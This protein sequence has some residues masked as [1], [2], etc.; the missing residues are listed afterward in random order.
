M[1]SNSVPDH[2]EKWTVVGHKKRGGTQGNKGAKNHKSYIQSVKDIDPKELTPE[3]IYYSSIRSSKEE[4]EDKVNVAEYLR[5]IIIDRTNILDKKDSLETLGLLTSFMIET[6]SSIIKNTTP[7]ILEIKDD[8]KIVITLNRYLESTTEINTGIEKSMDCYKKSIEG[9][10]SLK[11][12]S[13]ENIQKFL[14]T[15]GI[16]E[17]P[18]YQSNKKKDSEEFNVNIDNIPVANIQTSY[19]SAIG[20]SLSDIIIEKQPVKIVNKFSQPK[21]LMVDTGVVD[22]KIPVISNINDS[23]EYNLCYLDYC[24]VFVIRMGN[25][26]FTTGPGNFVDL[27]KSGEKTKHAKR[28]LN[29][30]PCAYKN[31]KYYHDPR[32][33]YEE[34]NTERNF[35]LSYIFQ[36]LG[37]VK[38]NTDLLDN[39]NIRS[40]HFL[41]DL[42]QLGGIILLRAAQIKALYFSGKKI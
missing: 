25:T 12:T 29:P 41:S 2:E 19:A 21:S 9:M 20:A 30:Q 15:C 39:K 26:V 38:N 3:D 28:C 17:V 11:K 16:D 10:D 42:V 27:K 37:S 34:F 40:P 22:I 33:V 23:I 1:S 13:I 18:I 32:V 14:T 36:M 6:M 8:Q 24:K 35:A 31:C 5:N 4:K 7:D